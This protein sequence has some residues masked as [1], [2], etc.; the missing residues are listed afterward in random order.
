MARFP[1]DPV[2]RA[3]A[4]LM[5]QSLLFISNMAGGDPAIISKKNL[6]SQTLL[7]RR[8]ESPQPIGL[9]TPVT[10]NG[11]LAPFVAARPPARRHGHLPPVP[12]QQHQS[13]PVPGRASRAGPARPKRHLAE[14]QPGGQTLTGARSGRI[15]RLL[16]KYGLID[17]KRIPEQR[18]LPKAGLVNLSIDFIMTVPDGLAIFARELI[19]P[20][21][22][23]GSYKEEIISH[24]RQYQTINHWLSSMIFNQGVDEL[25]INVMMQLQNGDAAHND[26]DYSLEVLYA[27]INAELKSWE[28]SEDISLKINT[29][30]SETAKNYIFDELVF[31]AMPTLRF[32]GDRN[33]AAYLSIGTIDW[34]YFHAGLLFANSIGISRQQLSIQELA[35]LGHSLDDMLSESVISTE[36]IAFFEL[37]AKLH[38]IRF[39]RETGADAGPYDVLQQ[40][41]NRQYALE[42]FFA[43]ND[44][45]QAANNPFHHLQEALQGYRTRHKLAEQQDIQ[46]AD[47]NEL[48]NRQNANIAEK[49]AVVDEL[50]II[51]VL[52]RADPGE[53]NFLLHAA[54]TR[55]SAAFS[56]FDH[57]KYYR[58]SQHVPRSGYTIA[59]LPNVDLL[60]AVNGDEKRI[61]ALQ[62]NSDG[63]VL[64]RVDQD[65]ER[66]YALMTD[67]VTCKKD[68]D[69]KFKIYADGPEVPVLKHAADKLA[70][71]VGKLVQK[72]REEVSRQLHDYGYEETASEQAKRILLGL[73]PLHDCIIGI[74]AGRRDALIPCSF[75]AFSFMPVAGKG[76]ALGGR[77]AEIGLGGG[78]MAFKASLGAIAARQSLRAALKLGGRHL[79]RYV[80]LPAAQELNRGALIELGVAALRTLDPGIE[81]T[82]MLGTKA[83]RQ[84]VRVVKTIEARV[85]VWQKVLPQLESRLLDRAPAPLSETYPMG[86]LAEL[87]KDVPVFKLHGDRFKGQDIYVRVNLETQQLFGKKYTLSA[88]N[89]LQPVPLPFAKKL[90]NLQTEGLGGRGAGKAG[91]AMAAQGARPAL[92]APSISS[93]RVQISPNQLLA[94]TRNHL[95][96][97]PLSLPEFLGR[98]NLAESNWR[99]YI[100]PEGALTYSGN[101]LLQQS[102]E[103]VWSYLYGLPPELQ[104]EILRPLDARSLN[105]ML[106]ALPEG[107]FEHSR[108]TTMRNLAMRE[109]DILK[110][111][112]YALWDAWQ[113]GGEG[114]ERRSM[115]V[116]KLKAFYSH[117]E[118]SLNFSV[119]SLTELPVLPVGITRLN[120]AS[121]RLRVL[122]GSLPHE[123]TH[124]KLSNNQLTLL[125]ENLPDT[126]IDLEVRQNA[127]IGLPGKLPQNLKRLDVSG[128]QLTVLDS[129]LPNS[130]DHLLLDHNQVTHFTMALPSSLTYLEAN[131]NHLAD[132]TTP[133]PPSLKY[134]SF[135]NNHFRNLP[136]N[137]PKSLT[138]LDVT[139]NQIKEIGAPLP[140]KLKTLKI[141]G[142]L[143]SDLPDNLPSHMT[144]IYADNNLLSIL[145]DHLPHKLRFLGVNKNLL[146]YLPPLP[147]SL[148]ILAAQENYIYSFNTGLP[149]GI[150]SINIA[151][152]NF[153]QL[154][155]HFPR[156]LNYLDVRGNDLPHRPINLPA[157]VKYIHGPIV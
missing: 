120:A 33:A 104:I 57:I 141:G 7:P 135:A 41:K 2:K 35:A 49:Y 147:D 118:S 154:P 130:L 126:L 103:P 87:D 74:Q 157:G 38:Y 145:P 96:E 84:I 146:T 144:H 93:A 17:E 122:T 14:A 21:G 94:W 134:L 80:I 1:G 62:S 20:S 114:M 77:I 55:I 149:P 34:G 95:G 119:L 42:A 45:I 106:L 18:E 86:R 101:L 156:T 139:N 28:Q 132:W 124:L 65:E 91:R 113:L 3:R 138:Y 40:E 152:N 54:I 111:S 116:A 109:F 48:F 88:A 68:K 46:N 137:L 32:H 110:N 51:D 78:T 23:Y 66:Y 43:A 79:M 67:S 127:L 148:K 5:L 97:A 13:W 75:D 10:G 71:L 89:V 26:S 47:I 61:F 108:L 4:E 143:M 50:M 140:V 27:R 25:V 59:L 133:W 24:E 73:I 70:V 63:Y 19:K 44:K 39:N 11:M 107:A 15:V 123:L 31:T 53:F 155:A 125:P 85:P 37:A 30:L 72:H 112:H 105:N 117:F 90:R 69:Y 153:N 60:L 115:A 12:V 121:N 22:E 129:A 9:P 76:I 136:D 142:N 56:A 128:N 100:T 58:F 150:E 64:E 52:Q 151:K 8:K 29:P 102:A 83:I 131:F 6:P 92:P 81:P 36:Y 99:Y 82:A 16:I 98:N